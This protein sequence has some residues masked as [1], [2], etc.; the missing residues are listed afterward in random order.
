VSSPSFDLSTPDRFTAGAVGVPGQRVFYLQAREAGR[1][2]TLKCEKEQVR[3]LGDYLAGLLE[4]VP[5]GGTALADTTLLEPLEPAWSVASIGVGYDEGTER[6]IV[7]VN[8]F[9]EEEGEE[10]A[11][12]RFAITR[13]QAAGYVDRARALMEAGRA[14]CPLCNLA[15]DP[16]GHVCPRRNGHAGHA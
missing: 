2:V 1:V 9:I 8:Q 13:A 12:A 11:T 6:V 15:I 4:K 10:P 7:V 16:G 5:G 14:I 3:A